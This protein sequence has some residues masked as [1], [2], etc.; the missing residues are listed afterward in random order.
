[1]RYER[2]MLV[3]QIGPEGQKKLEQS[4]VTVIGSGCLG[5]P[6][7]T[8]LTCAGVGSI[9]II[10][11][12]V[13][14]EPDLSCQF[15][16]NTNNL[17]ELKVLSAREK[18]SQLNPHVH[19][20]PVNKRLDDEN[21]QGFIAGSD[22]VVDC[23]DN[24]TSAAIVLHACT[25][26]G[27]PLVTGGA[28]G[29]CGWVATIGRDTPRLSLPNRENGEQRA[30][31]PLLGVT[32]GIIGSMQATECI[33]LLL[34]IGEPLFGRILNY[35]GLRGTWEEFRAQQPEDCPAHSRACP[36]KED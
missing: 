22:V 19:F 6:V 34:G 17:H 9:R 32:V 13:V 35:D 23:S 15:L 11:S 30:P 8:Y 26:L 4:A 1:M 5:S 16:H 20:I 31:V 2:Q 7:L 3:P 12:S 10:D 28:F 29:F 25:R 21:A 36:V 27:I 24:Q 14:S 18:L 33:K